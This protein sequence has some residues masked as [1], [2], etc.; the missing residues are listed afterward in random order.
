VSALLV[1]EIEPGPIERTPADLSVVGIFEGDRPLRGGAGRTDWRLCGRLSRLRA[2]GELSGRWGEAVLV[3]TFGGLG[4][5]LVV[6]LGLG[7]QSAF[8]LREQA[9]AARAA[10]GR[11]LALRARSLALP[12]GWGE[13]GRVDDLL[14]AALAGAGRALEDRPASLLLR[15]AV[16]GEVAGP[17]REILGRLASE[18]LHGAVTLEVPAIPS[19]ARTRGPAAA[20]RAPLPPAPP[21]VK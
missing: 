13:E 11:A 2:E 6:A 20:A 5:P 18:P 1:V 19:P 16:P 21:A 14:R 9:G 8:G 12:L 15:L 7:E 4:S 10:V 17:A 3:Q